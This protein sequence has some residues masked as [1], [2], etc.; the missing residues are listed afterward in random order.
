MRPWASRSRMIFISLLSQG[1][2]SSRGIFLDPHAFMNKQRGIAAVVD[3]QVRS[4]AVRPGQGL[5]RAPPVFFQRLP[6][7]GKDRSGIRLRDRGRRMV[8]GGK[9]VAGG[10]AEIGPQCF[11]R[12]DQHGRLNRHVETAGDFQPLERLLVSIFFP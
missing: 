11:E 2:L 8:L 3:D 5:F 7:P 6:F 10:P 1:C 9:D 12:F 4:R